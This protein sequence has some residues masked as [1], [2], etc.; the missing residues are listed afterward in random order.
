MSACQLLVA[1]GVLLIA[2]PLL[3]RGLPDP[4]AWSWPVIAS[5]VALGA[6]GTG[7]AFVINM[8]NIRLVGATTASMVTYVVPVFATLL[9]VLVLRESLEWFQP[10]GAL[11]VLLGV[12]VSQGLLSRR[13]AP[14]PTAERPLPL[15]S[16]ESGDGRT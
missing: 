11:V 16:G 3:S 14:K 15:C 6:V 12:A 2:A 7:L 10:V 4:T 13:R 9:G 5:V 8:R 1:T